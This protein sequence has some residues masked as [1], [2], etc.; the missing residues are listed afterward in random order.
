MKKIFKLCDYEFIGVTIASAHFNILQFFTI[1]FLTPPCLVL[2]CAFFMTAR[3]SFVYMLFDEDI[4][5]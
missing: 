1:P 2:I 3:S 4:V 5:R